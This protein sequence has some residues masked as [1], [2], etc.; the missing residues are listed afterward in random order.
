MPLDQSSYANASDY[1]SA[2]DQEDAQQGI[3]TTPSYYQPVSQPAPAPALP[4]RAGQPHSGYV[5][6]PPRKSMP[7]VNDE[8]TAD[9]TR[10]DFT[11]RPEDTNKSDEG[12]V[13]WSDYGKAAWNNVKQTGADLLGAVNYAD[14]SAQLRPACDAVGARTARLEDSSDQQH[15]AGCQGGLPS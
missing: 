5:P 9:E 1:H 8:F 11:F 3:P 15:V 7:T 14:R 6:P 12:K 13:Y 4:P 2:L 10:P